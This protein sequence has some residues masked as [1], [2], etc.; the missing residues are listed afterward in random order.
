MNP[1]DSTVNIAVNLRLF[2]RGEIGGL[3]NYV[4]HVVGG[5]AADQNRNGHPLTIL[6]RQS[7]VANVREIAPNARVV[8]VADEIEAE[9]ELNR[10]SYDLLF[11]P[12]L[13]LEP[14]RPSIP[15]AVM[16]PDVQHEFFPEFFDAATLRW[17][18]R[19]YRASALH[20]DVVYTL[21]EHARQTIVATYGV[22]P[23][24][25]EVIY[26]G[27]DPEFDEP[28]TAAAEAC[29]RQLG[30][31]QDYLYFPANFWPHKNHSTLLRAMQRLV[32]RFPDL[33][34]VCTGAPGTGTDRIKKEIARLG[35]RKNVQLLGYQDR[36]TVVELYRHARALVFPSRFEG[37][38]IPI[39]EAFHTLTPIVTSQFG[40]CREVAG[41]AAIIV[42]ELDPASIAAG[43]ERVLE[44]ADRCRAMVQRGT[45][46]ARQFS[47][48]RAIDL[49]LASLKR[50]ISG[51]NPAVPR[52]TVREPPLVSIVTPSY[53]MAEF[54][55]ETIQSVL[56]Q[57]YPHVEYVVMDGGSNDGTLDILRKYDGRLSF[58]SERDQGQADAVN[59]GFARSRGEIFAFLNAD[60]TYLPGALSTAVRHLSAQ[61]SIGVLYGEAYY[62]DE[63]GATIERYPTR[64]FDASLLKRNCFICQPSTFIRREVFEAVDGMNARLHFALD[65][66]LWIRIAQISPMRK[67]DDYLAT[68]RLH[69]NNKT[70]GQRGKIYREIMEVARTHYGYVP[71]DWIL[72][73]ASYLAEPRQDANFESSRPSLVKSA[74]SI[75]LGTYYNRRS[76]RPYFKEWSAHAGLASERFQDRWEDGWIS[77][78]YKTEH[79]IPDNC[80]RIR[81]EGRHLLPF[82]DGFHLSVLVDG[83][84]VRKERI[85]NHGPFTIEIDCAPGLRG[86]RHRFELRSTKTYQPI[87]NGDHRLLS[88]II[89]AVAFDAS[90]TKMR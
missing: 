34:L 57:D 84:T 80:S 86:R 65:Y 18:K 33:G 3:E 48:Q 22:D 49:T 36:K 11:C 79:V 61:S 51:S 37:F 23:S 74:L 15:S 77:Q 17:R 76:L 44:D 26:L 72:G 81:V 24:K 78:R 45:E 4:R 7:E 8:P 25:V 28:P 68:S 43:V 27:V 75:V 29:F 39:L 30:L 71:L 5:I 20:A 53:N 58:V 40:S 12:L 88:C 1:K 35:L 6:A 42:D 83:T 38:G 50:I 46:Q 2:T 70:L 87:E 54:L 31:P 64:P 52:I 56:S 62:T 69:R 10:G 21:S 13:V 19:T 41:D 66:D 9:A 90:E 67:I 85:L 82:E 89:D 16:I 63:Q 55:E 60:D 59:R 32:R 14:L 73:Y 47:W